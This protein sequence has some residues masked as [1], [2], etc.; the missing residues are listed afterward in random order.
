MGKKKIPSNA[1][2]KDFAQG[3]GDD[4]REDIEDQL[5]V[6]ISSVARDLATEEVSPVKTGFFASSWQVSKTRM[7]ADDQAIKNPWKAIE[8]TKGAPYISPRYKVPTKYKLNQSIFI[9]NR[10]EY[11]ERALLSPKSNIGAYIL[12]G[13]GTFKEGIRQ[14][15]DRIFTDK[16]PNINVLGL[17]A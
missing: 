2:A 11:T 15:I 7:P 13:S 8:Q 6:F 10:A 16:R 12:N 9:G 5:S 14:K 17:D 1:K 3:I 4:L